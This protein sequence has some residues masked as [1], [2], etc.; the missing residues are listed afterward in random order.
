AHAR[1]LTRFG[2]IGSFAYDIADASGVS[3]AAGEIS[4]ALTAS[5]FW[6]STGDRDAALLTAAVQT[7]K[8]FTRTLAVYVTSQQLPRLSVF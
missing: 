8:A 2:H 4:F 1:N 5:V 7:G 3:L 6:L